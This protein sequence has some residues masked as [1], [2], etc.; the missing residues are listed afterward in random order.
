MNGHRELALRRHDSPDLRHQWPRPGTGRRATQRKAEDKMRHP[1]V[2]HEGRLGLVLFHNLAL[3]APITADEEFRFGVDLTIETFCDFFREVPIWAAELGCTE[4]FITETLKD[5]ILFDRTIGVYGERENLIALRERIS[6]YIYDFGPLYTK[7]DY[8]VPRMVRLHRDARG[9]PIA[10]HA[11]KD[12]EQ[13]FT[14]FWPYRRKV[15]PEIMSAMAVPPFRAPE[16]IRTFA[17][18]ARA[19]F[20]ISRY[21]EPVPNEDRFAKPSLQ[22]PAGTLLVRDEK[23]LI[24]ARLCG[25]VV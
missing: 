25:L 5:K 12:A 11:D 16:A 17:G 19:P 22:R 23:D 21:D 14:R 6:D 15:M 18:I 20:A 24:V 10:A 4:F 9:H 2:V 3:A 1:G 7:R 8:H 13:M